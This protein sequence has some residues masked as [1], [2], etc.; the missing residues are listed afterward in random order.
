MVDLP[1]EN[2]D[3]PSFFDVFSMFTRPGIWSSRLHIQWSFRATRVEVEKDL[4]N[5][6]DGGPVKNLLD[7]VPV[8]GPVAPGPGCFL[9]NLAKIDL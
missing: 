3:F 1:I 2:G 4:L 9:A 7:T 8:A 6:A 5:G